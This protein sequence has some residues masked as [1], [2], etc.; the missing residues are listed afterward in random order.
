MQYLQFLYTAKHDFVTKGVI[1]LTNAQ[2]FRVKHL[3]GGNFWHESDVRGF[4][5]FMHKIV[6]AGCM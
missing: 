5:N 2:E 6:P 1:S 4:P 3:S